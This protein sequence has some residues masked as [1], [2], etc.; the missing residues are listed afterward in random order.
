MSSSDDDNGEGL[1][2]SY[3]PDCRVG[4][5]L[6]GVFLVFSG[7]LFYDFFSLSVP[8]SCPFTIFSVCLYLS[9]DDFF[10][11]FLLYSPAVFCFPIV[12]IALPGEFSEKVTV[13]FLKLPSRRRRI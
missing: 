11:L 5:L 8:L 1:T 13:W 4:R 6:V 2:G 7:T 9:M 12:D 10:L 3:I